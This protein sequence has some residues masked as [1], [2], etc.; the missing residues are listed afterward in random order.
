MVKKPVASLL[1]AG[2]KGALKTIK[3]SYRR[4]V[5]QEQE[6]KQEDQDVLS[7]AKEAGSPSMES[8]VPEEPPTAEELL[9]LAGYDK[10]DAEALPD[11]ED[12][13]ASTDT[14]VGGDVKDSVLARERAESLKKAKESLFPT[15]AASSDLPSAKWRLSTIFGPMSVHLSSFS[16]T[17][18]IFSTG[19]QN[20]QVPLYPWKEG[21]I[22]ELNCIFM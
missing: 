16:D 20:P 4:P 6:Q 14:Q 5:E 2:A 22:S 8:I 11:F 10:Q 19:R 13:S 21:L 9:T 3:G 18:L 15:S 7:E 17:Q 12:S 1:T